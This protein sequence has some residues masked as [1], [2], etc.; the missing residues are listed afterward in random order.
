MKPIINIASVI[1]FIYLFYI[2][3][4]FLF[5]AIGLVFAFYIFCDLVDKIGRYYPLKEI[6]VLVPLLQWVVGAKIS[7]SFGKVHHKYYMYVGEEEYMGYVVPAILFLYVGLNCIKNKMP[8]PKIEE[9]FSKQNFKKNKKIAQLLLVLGL[10]CFVLDKTAA[11]GGLAFIV[12]LGSLLLYVA[13]SYY[14]FLYP[15][16]K[17]YF[18]AGTIAFLLLISI[19]EGMFHTLL[20][21]GIFL[22]FLVFDKRHSFF[23]KL[24]VLLIGG[25]SVYT[26]QL[27]KNDYREMVWGKSNV[28]YIETFSTLVIQE[29]TSKPNQNQSSFTYIG[30]KNKE[31]EEQANLNV[32]LN[33]G[34]II[35]KV[36]DNVPKNVEFYKGETVI[37]TFEASLLPRAL[38]PNKPGGEQALKNFQEI[39]GLTLNKR[40]AMGLSVVAEF[41]ANYGKFGGWIAMLI[42]GLLLALFIRWIIQHG[43][44]SS[45]SIILWMSLFFFQ[46]IKAE[47]DLIKVVNHLIKSIIFFIA[48]KS[49][50]K[51]VNFNLFKQ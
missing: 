19:S 49:A 2:E 41:Y 30:A 13:S 32:R 20:L 4:Y 45:Y 34:W 1:L 24:V 3:G 48:L 51:A 50:L 46:V 26:I 29:F 8:I 15:K 28:N 25:F 9:S 40:T 39:T 5:T 23:S 12:Y 35:S 21:V 31:E 10:A 16:K 33:Q 22:T 47:T 27:V 6:I 18:F 7:Y 11:A 42:Y 38:F 37:Q 44:D 14:M 17:W 36:L 43:G